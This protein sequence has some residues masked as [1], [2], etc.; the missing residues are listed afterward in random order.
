MKFPIFLACMAAGCM[1]AAADFRGSE[2]FDRNRI[3]PE[4]MGVNIH[5]F[6]H[7][8]G[9]DALKSLDMRWLRMDITWDR[10]EREKG[11]YDFSQVDKLMNDAKARGLRVLAIIDYANKLYE[12]EQKVI[13]E[14]GRRAYS[15]YAAALVRRYAGHDVIWEIW[16][17]PNNSGF[18]PGNDPGE[19][20]ELVKAAVPAMREADPQ[21]VI[22]GPSAYRVAPEYMEACFKAGL[23]DYVDAVSFHPY[24]RHR[25]EE[26]LDDVAVLRELMRKYRGPGRELPPIVCDLF[27][28]E[29]PLLEAFFDQQ[30][31]EELA[32]QCVRGLLLHDFGANIIQDA[33]GDPAAFTGIGVLRKRLTEKFI[34]VFSPG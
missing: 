34:S 16:N 7:E 19:Y 9:M 12:P 25:P 33:L 5:F 22:L 4:G 27:A 3:V 2:L 29:P 15:A 26:V 6:D 20:M 14:A 32:G 30:S 31:A 21:A 1:L 24:R 10:V 8:S 13:S 11:V 23:F 18:W 28:F 17:E